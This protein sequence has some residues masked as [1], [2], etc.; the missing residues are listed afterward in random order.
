MIEKRGNAWCVVHGHAQK[1]GSKTDK[2]KGSVIKCYSFVPGNKTSEDTARK[3]AAAMHYAISISQSK[4]ASLFTKND[5]IYISEGEKVLAL[6]EKDGVFRYKKDMIKVGTYIHPVHKWKLS[7]TPERLT[8]WLVNFQAMRANGIDIEVPSDH[9]F[10]AEKNLGYVVDA[11]IEKDVNGVLTLFGILEIKGEQA[12][13]IVQRNKNVSVWISD[14]YV[15]GKGNFYG[16]VIKHCSVVQQPVM[17]GQET[18]IPIAAS[19]QGIE[20]ENIPIYFLRSDEMDKELLEKYKKLFGL[21]DDIT[22]ETLFSSIEKQVKAKDEAQKKI[23]EQ[24]LSL[25]TEVKTLKDKAAS[26]QSTEEKHIDPNT[27][28][29]VG[30]TM[31]DKLNLLVGKGNITPDVAKKLSAVIIGGQGKRNEKALSLGE[32]SSP[33]LATQIVE[34]LSGNDPVKLG[35]QTSSQALGREIP[36]GDNL[37]KP[38]KEAGDAMVMGAGGK[39]D[40]ESK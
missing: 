16:E 14:N 26:Q 32:N 28:E 2:P 18:F 24:V 13:N 8:R 6:G 39:L 37:P 29:L 38:D 19:S 40:K 17:P 4:A 22:E 30:T 21:G 9:S 5:T 36:G 20:D 12:N 3:K 23:Q 1:S 27:L 15:D 31:E 7:V 11:V 35:E 25:T 33:S 10:S 34:I